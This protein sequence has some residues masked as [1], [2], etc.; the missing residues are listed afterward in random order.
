MKK[1]ILITLFAVCTIISAFGVINTSAETTGTYGDLT[2][3]ISNNA[4]IITSCNTD[5]LLVEIPSEIGGYPVTKIG[6]YAFEGC[7]NLLSVDIPDTISIIGVDAF[8]SCN[9][10]SKINIHSIEAWCNIDLEKEYG[11]CMYNNGLY[12]AKKL[13]LNNKVITDLIIPE[14]VKTIKDAAF[15]Y[16]ES[17]KTVS[18]PDSVTTI[19]KS[20]FLETGLTSITIPSS[21]KSIGLYAFQDCKQLTKVN[22][23]DIT[24]WCK[25]DFS[26]SFENSN[27]P[28][29]Y[30]KNLYIND[31]LVTDLIIPEGVTY[32]GSYAF[33]NCNSIKSI[34]IPKS[35]KSI[36]ATAF[37]GCSNL[38]KVNIIDVDSWCNIEF[39]NERSNPLYYGGSL[40][41]N[42]NILTD[43]TLP[44]DIS[45]VNRSTF[46]NCKSLKNITIGS[47]IIGVTANAFYGC[48]N[49]ENVYFMGTKEEWDALLIASGNDALTNATLII[50]SP[51]E[52][53]ITATLSN[54][55]TLTVSGG[56]SDNKVTE[57]TTYIAVYDSSKRMIALKD[58]SDKE[59]S[60]FT[61]PFV[62]CGAA[63]TVK[64]MCWQTG[65]LMPLCSA[66]EISVIK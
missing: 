2:Y 56:L 66:I 14:G 57:G 54:D 9:S 50:N 48:N 31:T 29:F 37:S 61:I 22:I 40:Y 53:I 18:I 46:Y 60:D 44:N 58:A 63:H 20:A 52:P 3:R 32:I 16:C 26:Y 41:V 7:K 51:T 5:A 43:I 11:A 8:I 42:D 33:V 38:S 21:V 34:S 19:G 10:L 25:I 17:I 55:N 15:M 45:I 49:L 62:N 4:V 35:L 23:S 30:A 24:S 47:N 28:L 36:G 1:K 27:N 39:K 6:E 12:Y 65:T 13:Y 64:I 59:Q